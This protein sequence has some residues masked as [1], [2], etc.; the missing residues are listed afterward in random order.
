VLKS[1]KPVRKCSRCPLNRGA[2]CWGFTFP[3]DKWHRGTCP[4]FEN[5]A[6]YE[7]FFA[8]EQDP[9]VKTRKQIRQ[10]CFPGAKGFP[11]TGNLEG[12][13]GAEWRRIIPAPGRC[14]TAS[15][16]IR[17]EKGVQEL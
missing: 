9:P 11:S 3:R 16:R 8:W 12:R 14:S 17:S 13:N 15:D 4:A 1:R 7:L 6:A 5:D 2:F 10:A